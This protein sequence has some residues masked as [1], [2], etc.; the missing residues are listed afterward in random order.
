MSKPLP[1]VPQKNDARFLAFCDFLRQTRVLPAGGLVHCSYEDHLLVLEVPVVPQPNCEIGY[2]WF[3]C[4]DLQH[5]RGGEV[6]YGWSLWL[7]GDV[8][9]AQ[10]HAVWRSDT[11]QLMDPTPNEGFAEKALFMPDSRAP[12]DILTLRAPASL[13]RLANGK[14]EWRFGPHSSESFF[15]G[16]MAPKADQQARIDRTQRRYLQL[17]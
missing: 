3:N 6:V 13:D 8:F 7:D 5:L 9:V 11:G 14:Y 1:A 10:H 4:L 17:A 16:R 12:F 15:I 2:C